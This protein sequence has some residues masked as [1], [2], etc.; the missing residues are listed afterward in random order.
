MA[1]TLIAAKAVTRAG[2]DLASGLTAGDSTNDMYMS[3]SGK[4]LLFVKNT[5]GG[6]S[7]VTLKIAAK[8]DGQAVTDRT[9]TVA[10]TTGMKIIGPFP[11]EYYGETLNV[12][13]D[14]STGVT[15]ASL[16]ASG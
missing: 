15:L 3:N 13:L 7:V 1:R 8:V 4:E 12:D 16:T 5:G 2:L 9:V 14:V 6:A 10:A 11:T